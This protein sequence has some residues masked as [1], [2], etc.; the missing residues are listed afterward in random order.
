[1]LNY[2]T[3]IYTKGQVFMYEVEIKL[4][5]F[6]WYFFIWALIYTKGQD[7]HIIGCSNFFFVLFRVYWSLSWKVMIH[8]HISCDSAEKRPWKS[9]F[10]FKPRWLKFWW[11]HLLKTVCKR[12][13]FWIFF[14]LH[15]EVIHWN[16]VWW[17]L[18]LSSHQHSKLMSL[19]HGS[20]LSVSKVVCQFPVHAHQ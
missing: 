9:I 10:C 17:D 14:F 18:D 16:T 5:Y 6:I 19:G 4:C 15:F 2:V 1:M 20:V 11:W 13:L 12:Q 3:Y 7:L 8:K